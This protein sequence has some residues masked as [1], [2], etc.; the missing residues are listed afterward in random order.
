MVCVRGFCFMLYRLCISFSICTGYSFWSIRAAAFTNIY[1][2][3]AGITFSLS[4]QKGQDNLIKWLLATGSVL[5]SYIY[6][7]KFE[8]S[9]V[10]W[11][12]MQIMSPWK[13][14]VMTLLCFLA[15]QFA[16]GCKSVEL[17]CCVGEPR[18][19]LYTEQEC[20]QWREATDL[21]TFALTW[22]VLM[23]SC[24]NAEKKDVMLQEFRL[25]LEAALS[26]HSIKMKYP[27]NLA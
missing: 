1:R 3:W 4:F 12:L 16:V 17:T 6:G 8:C 25:Y 19:F 20:Q 23:S 18:G 7:L 22:D 13:Q 9:L 15:E 26:L 2:Q 21:S 5:K 10:T 14:E 27:H 11:G 24:V